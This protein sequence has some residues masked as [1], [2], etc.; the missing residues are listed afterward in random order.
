MMDLE[1]PIKLIFRTKAAFCEQLHVVDRAC[2]EV[3]ALQSLCACFIRRAGFE[4]G[5]D[6]FVAEN[7]ARNIV[8]S[9]RL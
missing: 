3:R 7:P 2:C 5:T 6:P 8:L 1:R 9:L 4:T